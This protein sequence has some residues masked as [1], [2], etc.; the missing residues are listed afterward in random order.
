MIVTI[1]GVVCGMEYFGDRMMF[2]RDAKG[3]LANSY[4]P[5]ARMDTSGHMSREVIDSAIEEF[6]QELYDGKRR[7]DV[8]HH[9]D[10][11]VYACAV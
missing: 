11:L 1:D 7:T 5:E 6:I 9:N 2:S 3:I 10:R 4:V 8:V